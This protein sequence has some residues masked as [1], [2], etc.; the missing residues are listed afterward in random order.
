LPS[1]WPAITRPTTPIAKTIVSKLTA[2]HSWL[3]LTVPVRAPDTTMKASS[4]TVTAASSATII[5]GVSRQRT[6]VTR[7]HDRPGLA[8]P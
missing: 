5:R 7:G 4:A 8:G 1:C 3:C 6:A 2:G